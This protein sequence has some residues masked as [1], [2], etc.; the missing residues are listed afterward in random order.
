MMFEYPTEGFVD[1]LDTNCVF[2][3]GGLGKNQKFCY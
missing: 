2:F 3:S 1:E